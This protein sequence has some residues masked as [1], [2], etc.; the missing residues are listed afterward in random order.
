MVEQP[1]GPHAAAEMAPFMPMSPSSA[2]QSVACE[3]A[4]IA[5]AAARLVSKKHIR[6]LFDISKI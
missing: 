6:L 1:A 2:A 4:I 3:A 5:A